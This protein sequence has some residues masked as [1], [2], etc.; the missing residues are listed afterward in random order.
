MNAKV[1]SKVNESFKGK[2]QLLSI[3]EYDDIYE[4]FEPSNLKLFKEFIRDKDGIQNFKYDPPKSSS[5]MA[6]LGEN[7]IPKLVDIFNIF[8]TIPKTLPDSYAVFFRDL[9][10]SLE[11]TDLKS[12]IKLM[13]LAKTVRPNGPVINRKLQDYKNKVSSNVLSL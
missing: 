6:V 8:L 1:T 10:I 2:S 4:S 7:D 11:D 5:N 12:A 3:M 13:E 9:A